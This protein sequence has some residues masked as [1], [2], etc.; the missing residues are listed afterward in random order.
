MPTQ[1]HRDLTIP[2]LRVSAIYEIEETLIKE[3]ADALGIQL[4]GEEGKRLIKRHTENNQAHEAYLKGR[5]EQGKV[6]AEGSRKAIQYFE[7]ATAKDS[8]YALAYAASSRSYYTLAA[9]FAA[10][11]A[12]EALPR[13]EDMARRALEIDDGLAEAHA[14]MGD[15]RRAYWDELGAEEEYKIAVE[16]DP[17]SYRAHYGYAFALSLMAHHDEAIARMRRAQQL[18]PL[19]LEARI[20]AATMFI[21]ARRWHEAIE[22]L[23]GDPDLEYVSDGITQ[24]IINRLSQL[25]GL[26]KVISSSSVMGYKGKRV[27]ARTVTQEVE[28]RAVVMATMSS[29]GDNI[30]INVTVLSLLALLL[31]LTVTA[32][33]EAIDSIAVLPIENLS[34]DPDLEYVS[35]GITQGIINRLS[36]LSGLNKVISSS[37]VMGYKGKRVD[38]RTV[39]QEVEV[40][41]VV[42]ATMSSQGDN[43]RINVELVDGEDNSTLWGE[44]YTRPRSAIYEIEETLSKEIADALGIQLS[45]E[46]GK[47]LI[48]RHTENNQAHEA[49][50]KGRAE[51]GKVAAEGSR[52][53]IQYFEEATAKDS[54][55]ALAY[56]ASSRSYYTLAQG[57]CHL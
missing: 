38:A 19:A 3:I 29:Q 53:A 25:S 16:L 12:P 6:A 28:V 5:A 14:A 54:N 35:D 27:D 39:T 44:T 56:A 48:K 2:S 17:G 32:P 50:L 55:Y 43:I 13:A 4:S 36:Q 42:M 41:A 15:V 23:S 10:M 37:S 26:N 11:P 31:P 51:Q 47:R 21:N 24:G 7:E 1:P 52:K 18:D 46:E 9:V 33:T 20:G 34:G 57:F 30:R 49:Y 40:R 22:N 8:N 45:G